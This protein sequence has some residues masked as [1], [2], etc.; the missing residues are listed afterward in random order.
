MRPIQ[1]P[2][3]LILLWT[4]CANSSYNTI[5]VPSESPVSAR[6]ALLGSHFGEDVLL[7]IPS[8][9]ISGTLSAVTLDTLSVTLT[10]DSTALVPIAEIRS[11]SFPGSSGPAVGLG[12]LGAAMGLVAGAAAGAALY[13]ESGLMGD[14]APATVGAAVGMVVLGGA[15]II[16]GRD[17]GA[18]TRYL[19]DKPAHN[20]AG[21]DSA[22]TRLTGD[23]AE[24]RR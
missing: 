17:A 3:L 2:L 15:G 4:G 21:A 19:F 8:D 11:A 7:Q 23:V 14:F 24:Y 12:I 18:G 10:S 13:D 1:I 16:I 22:A 5:T 20:T 6:A 9:E